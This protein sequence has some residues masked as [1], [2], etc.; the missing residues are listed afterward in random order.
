MRERLRENAFACRADA[1]QL[2][3]DVQLLLDELDIGSRGGGK[4]VAGL[5]VV[6]GLVP[7]GK[8]LPDRGGVVEVAL[9]RREMLGLG[10]IPQAVGDA[11]REL[12]EVG[13]H[14]E[15]R[16]GERGDAVDANGVTERDEV[17]PAAAAGAAG[18]GAELASELAEA[19]LVGA[20]DLGR[21][22]ALPTR[23]T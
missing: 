16:Q 22:R 5:G 6:E 21:E 17:E 13:E 11:D 7:A 1:D 14:V 18:D 3:G 10:S 8:D 12:D 15:L 9:V 4:G 20:L 2:H 19:F 23:V